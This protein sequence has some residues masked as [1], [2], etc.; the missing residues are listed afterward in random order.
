L[1][2]ACAGVDVSAASL[3]LC[4]LTGDGQLAV[5]RSFT[6][7]PAGIRALLKQLP[8]QQP[9]RLCLEPTSRYHE[10]LARALAVQD[11]CCL[12]LANPR[13]VHAFA[14]SLGQRAKTDRAD[15]W[16]LARLAACLPAASAQP[17]SQLCCDLRAIVGRINALTQHAT[18]EKNRLRLAERCGA[19]ACVTRD[20]KSQLGALAR[21]SAALERQAEE[22]LAADPQLARRF[23]LLQ[24]VCGIAHKAGLQLLAGLCTLPPH[25]TKRQWVAFAGLDPQPRESGTS[26]KPRHISRRGD[27]ELRRALLMPAQ[28]AVRHCPPLKQYYERLLGRGKKPLQALTAVMAKLL[29]II[30]AMW[31]ADEPF[32]AARIG[33]TSA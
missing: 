33:V 19:P 22:L 27:P 1:S 3:E 20:L 18:Q 12:M 32:D 7:T 21:S 31:R 5:R 28:V 26:A 4:L 8:L 23:E 13:E 30:W 9:L 14:V 10:R 2:T 15:A 16:L 11:N 17:P 24:T 6:N 29:H 25:L